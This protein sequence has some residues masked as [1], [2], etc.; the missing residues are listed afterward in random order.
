MKTLTIISKGKGIISDGLRCANPRKDDI[1]KICNK[2]LVKKN[3]LGQIAGNFLCSR[4]DQLIEVK[5]IVQSN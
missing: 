4:C 2:L 5:L 1:N 3:I